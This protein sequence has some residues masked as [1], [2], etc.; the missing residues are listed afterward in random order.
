MSRMTIGWIM[1]A[2]VFGSALLA[3]FARSMLCCHKTT[4]ALSRRTP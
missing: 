1:F 2:A 3:M 4:L